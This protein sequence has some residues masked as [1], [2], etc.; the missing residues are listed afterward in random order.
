MRYEL[1]LRRS[2]WLADLD[3][4]S[5]AH[6]VAEN[7]L[8][9]PATQTV[10]GILGRMLGLVEG[11]M[12]SLA[13][14]WEEAGSGKVEL[15]SPAEAWALGAVS[16]RAQAAAA[17]E[18]FDPGYEV[19]PLESI[20]ISPREAKRAAIAEALRREGLGLDEIEAD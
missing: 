14:T 6:A 19:P 12:G 20:V 17:F 15:P 3:A 1:H 11:V 9:E 8:P 10:A 2:P 13:E 5:G 7:W 4:L 18:G 16:E